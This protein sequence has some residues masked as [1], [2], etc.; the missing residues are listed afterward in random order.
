MPCFVRTHDNTILVLRV[1]QRERERER[2]RGR[3][4][5]G[6]GCDVNDYVFTVTLETCEI[7][8]LIGFSPVV[9]VTT[10]SSPKS[11]NICL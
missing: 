10:K 5:E 2:E 1:R 3:E 8:T 7:S 6:G 9:S 11:Q 4:G